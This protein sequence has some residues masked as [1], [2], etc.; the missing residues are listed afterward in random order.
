MWQIFY[1][2]HYV[3]GRN[4]RFI[5]LMKSNLLLEKANVLNFWECTSI[6]ATFYVLRWYWWWRTVFSR[7]GTVEGVMLCSTCSAYR[8]GCGKGYTNIPTSLLMERLPV[9]IFLGTGKTLVQS[10]LRHVCI[11]DFVVTSHL[12]INYSPKCRAEYQQKD[13]PAKYFCFCGKEMN[14]KFDPW[15]VPHS[16]GQTCGQ[17]LKPECGHSCLLL[18]HP[19]KQLSSYR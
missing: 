10:L 18:C 19:G 15:L 14:P 13:C 9:K 7:F 11:F 17:N 2:I 6:Q 12:Q 5:C 1:R 8:S 16:C 4:F 3:A